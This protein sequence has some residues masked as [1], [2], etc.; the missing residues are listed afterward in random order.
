MCS[1]AWF[2][3]G[4]AACGEAGAAANRTVSAAAHADVLMIDLNRN[5]TLL[6]ILLGVTA[7]PRPSQNRWSSWPRYACNIKMQTRHSRSETRPYGVRASPTGPAAAGRPLATSAGGAFNALCRPFP[8][9]CKNARPESS[10]RIHDDIQGR[11]VGPFRQLA[12]ADA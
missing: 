10:S 1:K 12:G 7:S 8:I 9:D 2:K 6:H 11:L 4:S 5:E 3:A